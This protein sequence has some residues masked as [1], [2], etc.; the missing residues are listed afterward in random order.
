V[1]ISSRFA[2]FF[3]PVVFFAAAFLA[4]HASAEA[5]QFECR[6]STDD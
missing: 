1:S 6:L 2:A 3:L 5:V 4:I